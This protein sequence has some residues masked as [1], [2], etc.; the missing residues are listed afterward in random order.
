[1]LKLGFCF[2]GTERPLL[3]DRQKFLQFLVKPLFK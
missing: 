1:M 2:Q 3:A